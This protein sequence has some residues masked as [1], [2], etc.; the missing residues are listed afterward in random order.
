M[1]TKNP[2]VLTDNYRNLGNSKLLNK[3]LNETSDNKNNTIDYNKLER[4]DEEIYLRMCGKFY[5]LITSS[6]ASRG[7]QKALKSTISPIL[8][9]IFEEVIIT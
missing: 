1:F 5:D 9:K 8:S 2:K 7:I 6:Y 4:I 3:K